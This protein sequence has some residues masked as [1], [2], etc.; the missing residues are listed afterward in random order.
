ML[1]EAGKP[2]PLRGLQS[3]RWRKS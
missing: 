3:V 2:A 1:I